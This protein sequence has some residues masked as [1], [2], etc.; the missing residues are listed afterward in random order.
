M[1]HDATVPEGKESRSVSKMSS[2]HEVFQMETSILT[3]QIKQKTKNTTKHNI[4]KAP[5]IKE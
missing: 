1:L 2:V 3:D 5:F 4:Q